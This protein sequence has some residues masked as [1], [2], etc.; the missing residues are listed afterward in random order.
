MLALAALAGGLYL[1]VRF[2]VLLSSSTWR[3]SSLYTFGLKNVV[4]VDVMAIAFGFVLRVEGGAAAIGV[5]VSTWL[6][7]C[8]T[9]VALFLAFSKRR[10]ELAAAVG[11][12]GRPAPGPDRTTARRSSIR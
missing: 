5:R 3:S 12:G 4:I 10:H 9:F 2:T 1:G 11:E 7:L 6:L 8:T